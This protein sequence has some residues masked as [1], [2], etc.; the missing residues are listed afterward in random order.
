MLFDALQ[1]RNASLRVCHHSAK[2]S[3]L[4]R[5]H[6]DYR[7]MSLSTGHGPTCDGI[8]SLHSLTTGCFTSAMKEDDHFLGRDFSR[9]I[10]SDRYL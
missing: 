8:D 7:L 6:V 9:R 2:V 4:L 1:Q 10:N 3:D 5:K